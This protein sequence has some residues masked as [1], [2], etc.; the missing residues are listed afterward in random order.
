MG[1]NIYT[2]NISLLLSVLLLDAHIHFIPPRGGIHDTVNLW[3]IATTI[4]VVV[5]FVIFLK[6]NFRK[7][8]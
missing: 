4:S 2:L 8:K 7:I 6:I 1:I 5:Y 3:L